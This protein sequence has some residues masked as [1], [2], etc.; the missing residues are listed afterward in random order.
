M[1]FR[2]MWL[3][4][5]VVVLFGAVSVKA[6]GRFEVTPFV[7]YETSASYPL[8]YQNNNSHNTH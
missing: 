7:G 1:N 5:M 3:F 2:T 6:Q 4:G 8:S